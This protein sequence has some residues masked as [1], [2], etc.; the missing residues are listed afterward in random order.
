MYAFIFHFCTALALFSID[1]LSVSYF[2]L[3]Q[4]FM[5]ALWYT[6][7]FLFTVTFFMNLIFI[8]ELCIQQIECT[9]DV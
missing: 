6:L 1:L 9:F 5:E 7:D 2:L 8:L 3:I 4:Y